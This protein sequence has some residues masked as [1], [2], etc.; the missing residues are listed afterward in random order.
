MVLHSPTNANRKPF[1]FFKQWRKVIHL[2]II[3]GKSS[4]SINLTN[5]ITK[6]NTMLSLEF[7]L[8]SAKNTSQDNSFFGSLDVINRLTRQFSNLINDKELRKTVGRGA[9]T[10]SCIGLPIYYSI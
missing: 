4:I 9:S 7:E 8:I 3:S 6:K 10:G 2:F 1:R 5:S